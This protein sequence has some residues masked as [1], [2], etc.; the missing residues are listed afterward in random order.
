[1][2]GGLDTK[3]FL[4]ENKVE[5]I[6]YLIVLLTFGMVIVLLILTIVL[7]SSRKVAER[8]SEKSRI[9]AALRKAGSSTFFG[10]ES[11]TTEQERQNVLRGLQGKERMSPELIKRNLATNFERMS[12]ELIKRD[13][14]SNFERMSPELIKRNL[15]TNFEHMTQEEKVKRGLAGGLSGGSSS[16]GFINH[17]PMLGGGRLTDGAVALR[18]ADPIVSEPPSPSERQYM[19][20][21]ELL[22]HLLNK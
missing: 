17:M 12:P 19:K 8:F 5:R 20:E 1:M 10:T 15:A 16:E 9:A 4:P 22:E 14:A 21:N 6:H 3:D 7:L 2:E 13:L 18:A 11:L